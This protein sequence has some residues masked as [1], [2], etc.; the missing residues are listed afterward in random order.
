[1]HRF[2]DR[3]SPSADV[4]LSRFTCGV[5]YWEGTY[6]PL[7]PSF[8]DSCIIMGI[9]SIN[10]VSACEIFVQLQGEIAH[11]SLYLQVGNLSISVPNDERTFI[12]LK[13]KDMMADIG[14]PISSLVGTS[15]YVGAMRA[16]NTNSDD[17]SS[18]PLHG[19]S[20]YSNGTAY[21]YTQESPYSMTTFTC[22]SV[23]MRTQFTV[24]IKRTS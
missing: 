8:I 24:R 17:T 21:L 22:D 4:D 3:A 20:F 6:T 12:K 15:L 1:M 2:M 5:G 14:V 9:D 10:D 16:T 11:I 18:V 13:I 23:S 7:P 19:K